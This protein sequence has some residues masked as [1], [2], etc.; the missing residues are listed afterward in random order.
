MM[1]E[2]L[3]VTGAA[4]CARQRLVISVLYPLELPEAIA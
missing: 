2:R 3:E 4:A 1:P